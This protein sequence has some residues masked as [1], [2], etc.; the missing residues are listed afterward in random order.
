MAL[1]LHAAELLAFWAGAV[2]QSPVVV[3]F[4]QNPVPVQVQVANGGFWD[5]WGPSILQTSVSLA[6][7][8]AAV[9][10]SVVSFRNNRRLANEQWERNQ[11]AA[12]DQWIRDQKKAEWRELIS[13]VSAIEEHIPVLVEPNEL[14]IDAL[15]EAI[16]SVIP[17]LR[18]RI[19][20]HDELERN[21]YRDQW[22]SLLNYV[23]RG[24][25]SEKDSFKA[26]ERTVK[27]NGE[28]SDPSPYDS[29]EYNHKLVAFNS[30]QREV[31]DRWGKLMEELRMLSHQSL[32]TKD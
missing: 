24:L 28:Q 21:K 15:K 5:K 4:A 27:R 6:S 29:F 31:R 1:A 20:I 23:I 7:I 17:L 22:L 10:I 26:C 30:A 25:K 18:D 16:L 12:H 19:F 32:G 14:D 9:I 2:Q 8:I 3:K 13:K 11:N